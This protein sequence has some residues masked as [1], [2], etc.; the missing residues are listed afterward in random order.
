MM[1][2]TYAKARRRLPAQQ[3][4]SA[5]WDKHVGDEFVAKDT[6]ATLETIVPNAYVVAGSKYLTGDF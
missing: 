1:K 3:L 5:L 2:E 6:T 4:F